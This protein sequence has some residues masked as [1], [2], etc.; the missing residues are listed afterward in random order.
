MAVLIAMG[1]S[2][3][4]A[5]SSG[6]SPLVVYCSH[7]S[8][9]SEPIIE[10]FE[11]ETG[12][13]VV[14]VP[15]TEASKSLGLT[16]RILAERD[17][18][19]C[20]VFWNNQ[21]LGTMDLAAAG[22]LE[23]YQGPGYQRIPVGYKDAEGLWAGFAA[24]MRV[25]IVNTDKME[26]TR[27]AVENAIEKGA[28]AK[29]TETETLSH[30]AIAKP[31]YG[32]TRTHYTV[33]WDVKTG[34]RLKQ[35]HKDWRDRGVL[36]LTGNGTV[37]REVGAGNVDLGLTDTDDYFVAKD[38]GKPVA[39]VPAWVA[40]KVDQNKASQDVKAGEYQIVIPN[41]VAIIK[42][43]NQ[44]ENAQ[45]FVDYLLSKK[46]ELMLAKSKARQI[47]L[48]DIDDEHLPA[49]VRALRNFVKTGYPLSD[50]HASREA[51][52]KWLRQEYGQ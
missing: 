49:E 17:Q 18:P 42:G 7:D 31:L 40:V 22:V 6:P 43:T 19:R 39:M 45:R 15:D 27:K 24:R 48:G 34:D 3:W 25:W 12:I 4:F 11:K 38:D 37:M 28:G 8:V 20:D 30:V 9:F 14:F 21:Q 52:L 32:T 35:W 1:T 2:Y 41:T 50:L 10:A 16:Q 29:G 23:P 33:L 36:E 44:R 13:E 46:V 47:P 51:C 5:L 26:A